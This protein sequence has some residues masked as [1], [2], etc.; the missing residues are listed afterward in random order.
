MS[1]E[2]IGLFGGTFDPVHVGHLAIVRCALES[3]LDRL[4]V[5]P[6]RASPHKLGPASSALADG[7]ERLE[8]LRLAL[9]G[10][11][12]AEVSRFEIDRPPPSYTRDSLRFL[13]VRNPAA[14]I[15]IMLGWDQFA[16]LDKWE[17]FAEWAPTIEFLVFRRRCTGLP[18]EVPMAVRGLRHQIVP[19]E[20]PAI[21]S[22]QIRGAIAGGED[23]DAWLHP[24]VARFA[25]ER[26][27]Y[28][29]GVVAT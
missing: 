22:T 23:A 27:L 14:V 15:A 8:M 20:I 16:V 13:R 26:G 7:E 18:S 29:P 1:H 17:G 2:K 19:T 25:R 5:M 12:R 24:A 11:A 9:A 6:C 4:V 28:R 3:G 10:E 21:S